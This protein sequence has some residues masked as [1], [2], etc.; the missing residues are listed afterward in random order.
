MFARHLAVSEGVLPVEEWKSELLDKLKGR[1][2]SDEE[3]ASELLMMLEIQEAEETGKPLPDWI[4]TV[5][6]PAA[7]DVRAHNEAAMRAL[8]ERG[9]VQFAPLF[10]RNGRLLDPLSEEGLAILIPL[11]EDASTPQLRS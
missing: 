9:L 4:E 11:A 8:A 10:N 7:P 1:Q 2:V 3:A 5:W 6:N